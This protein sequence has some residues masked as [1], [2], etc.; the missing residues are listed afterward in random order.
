MFILSGL[1]VAIIAAVGY[2]L[3]RIRNLESELPDHV[4]DHAAVA[5]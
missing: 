2:A 1:L 5:P 4:E 3:P